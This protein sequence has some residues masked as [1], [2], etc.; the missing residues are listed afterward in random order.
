MTRE[1]EYKKYLSLKPMWVF[2][3]STFK[4]KRWQGM[5]IED[6]KND[7]PTKMNVNR[8]RLRVIYAQYKK[9]TINYCS[10]NWFRLKYNEWMSKKDLFK[11]RAKEPRLPFTKHDTTSQEVRNY[12]LIKKKR[13]EQG[14]ILKNWKW[15]LRESQ[16]TSDA[17]P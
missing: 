15:I 1:E 14:Y 11:L 12:R 5:S 10:L 8:S 3:L 2:K 17:Y 4:K 9:N 13:E 6:I 7:F 16:R